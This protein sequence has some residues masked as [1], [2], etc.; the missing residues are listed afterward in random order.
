[1]PDKIK[2]LV[3]DDEVDFL[4]TITVRLQIR[5]FDVRKAIDGVTAIQLAEEELF[6]IALLDLKMPGLD[7]FDVL[8][9]LKEKHEYLEVIILT[10]HGSINSA[11]ETSKYGA[12]RFLTKPYDFDA[13][14]EFIKQAYESRLER[15]FADDKEI[16]K[17]IKE[18]SAKIPV[19]AES[20]LEILDKLRELDNDIK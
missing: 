4:D 3:V 13:L 17:K 7:G 15:K 2:I 6:D 19:D 9:I 5:G 18:R 10:A 20:A 12:F 16:Y 14:I 1:M 8:K 11:F